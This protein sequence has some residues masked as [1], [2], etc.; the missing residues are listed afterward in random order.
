[1]EGKPKVLRTT[2]TDCECL[3][4]HA[5]RMESRC[6]YEAILVGLNTWKCSRGFM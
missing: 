2:R 3:E 5:D 1:M 6:I 4:G